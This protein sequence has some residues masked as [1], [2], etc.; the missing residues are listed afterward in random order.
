M[1]K[2]GPAEPPEIDPAELEG[3]FDAPVPMN[4]LLVPPQVTL[5]GEWLEFRY[6]SGTARARR[7]RPT[8]NLLTEFLKLRDTTDSILRY[9][10]DWG[11]LGFCAHDLPLDQCLECLVPGM[12]LGGHPKPATM[13]SST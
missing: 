2:N 5:N 10:R 3:R 8:R 12:L 7:R 4:R 13:L 11:P 9:A 6:Y 1:R